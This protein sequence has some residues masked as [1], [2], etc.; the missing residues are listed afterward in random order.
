MQAVGGRPQLVVNPCDSANGVTLYVEPQQVQKVRSEIVAEPLQPR[1]MRVA[2]DGSGGLAALE[3]L[4]LCARKGWR[5]AR[6]VRHDACRT[7][8]GPG[9][10]G[11]VMN[12]ELHRPVSGPLDRRHQLHHVIVQRR[13]HDRLLKMQRLHNDAGVAENLPRRHDRHLEIG[14][15]RQQRSAPDDMVLKPCQYL[16]TEARGPNPGSVGCPEGRR[17]QGMPAGGD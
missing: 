17:Q 2:R 9:V 11:V 6:V 14:T 3:R 4:D 16:H 10:G 8:E 5:Y 1:G 7:G 15:R 12:V 13:Q